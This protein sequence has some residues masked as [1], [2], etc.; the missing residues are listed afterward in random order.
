MLDQANRGKAAGVERPNDVWAEVSRSVVTAAEVESIASRRFNEW[1]A[2]KD[3]FLSLQ[4]VVNAK[5]EAGTKEQ[6]LLTSMRANYKQLSETVRDETSLA[7]DPAGISRMDLRIH[8]EGGARKLANPVAEALAA[9]Y[10][11]WV[12]WN[13]GESVQAI[14]HM[15]ES[16]GP[17]KMEDKIA[18]A[19]RAQERSKNQIITVDS[20]CNGDG[21]SDFI[22]EILVQRTIRSNS[23]DVTVLQ[24][25]VFRGPSCGPNA[26]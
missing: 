5:P 25:P 20:D 19:R 14:R 15:I 10:A 18:I 11:D 1:D 21:K 12:Q 24:T 26:R 8:H 13:P 16:V 23:T 7:L 3:G 6:M 4:E 9:K 2:S 22:N 17:L